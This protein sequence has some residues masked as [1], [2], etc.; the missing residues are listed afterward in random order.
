MEENPLLAN[1]DV[2]PCWPEHTTWDV[3]EEGGRFLGAADVPESASWYR[4][5]YIRD[6][7]FLSVTMDDAG[8]IMVKR[9]RLVLPGEQ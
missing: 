3:F 2:E 7:M 1:N 4:Y 8:T 5:P 9:Y 6:D